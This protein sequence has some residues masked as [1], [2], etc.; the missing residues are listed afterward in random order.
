MTRLVSLLRWHLRQPTPNAFADALC[1]A[2]LFG[3]L[4]AILWVTP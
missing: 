3:W 2:C 1:V 4:V